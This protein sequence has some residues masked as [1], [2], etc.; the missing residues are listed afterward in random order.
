MKL[1]GRPSESDSPIFMTEESTC[2][3]V[4]AYSIR[5]I[6]GATKNFHENNKLDEGAFGAV[7][8]GRIGDQDVAVKQLTATRAAK[9]RDR[10]E[11]KYTGAATFKREAEVLGKYRHPNIV[12]LLGHCMGHSAPC[13]VYEFMEGNALHVRLRHCAGT[14]RVPE[15]KTPAPPLTW[16]ERL[17]VASD[18][19][20]GLSFLHR[21]ATPVIHQDI[22]SANILLRGKGKNVV[23]KLADFGT[24]RILE[25]HLGESHHS[26][27]Q[28]VGT[29]PYMP[30]EYSQSGHV[31]AKTDTFAFGVVL[32]EMITGRPPARALES[33]RD[34]KRKG[35]RP[36]QG[37]RGVMNLVTDMGKYIE[38][39]ENCLEEVYDRLAGEYNAKSA[40]DLATLAKRCTEH[41]ASK[42][43]VVADVENQLHE[44][45]GRPE[46]SHDDQWA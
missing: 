27:K 28:L 35:R 5:E 34:G 37:R 39:P 12:S 38:D 43:C 36:R 15:G 22:K 46:Q 13:L 18:M 9:D 10:G 19:A 32:L 42:R 40:C 14:G 26:T 24:I 29:T 31:S 20:R 3:L 6:E 17:A 16:D 8:K 25:V 4:K 33:P 1:G 21:Q 23:A 44:L 7:F 41:F 30:Y 11:G 45:A 2:A